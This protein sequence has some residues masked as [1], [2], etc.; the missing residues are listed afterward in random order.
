MLTHATTGIIS[1]LYVHNSNR[2]EHW[3]EA[4][5]DGRNMGNKRVLQSFLKCCTGSS[6]T[7][8][9]GVFQRVRC[10]DGVSRLGGTS[11]ASLVNGTN[12]ELVQ[13]SFLE[14]KYR[15][16]AHFLNV[17]IAAHPLTLTHIIS[18]KEVR[19]ERRGYAKKS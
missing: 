14:S 10:T 7:C 15:V 16:V 11:Y 9:S 6:F 13:T 19:K 2:K 17:R 5:S 12:P 1:V 3:E 18:G 8:Y 4:G